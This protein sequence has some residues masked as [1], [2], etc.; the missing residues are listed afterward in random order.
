MIKDIIIHISAG[1]HARLPD[2]RAVTHRKHHDP[3][4]HQDFV[5]LLLGPL[6]PS[7]SSGKAGQWCHEA[8]ENRWLIQPV[9]PVAVPGQDLPNEIIQFPALLIGRRAR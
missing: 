9:W 3:G 1:P 7:L 8:A 4:K 5:P 6:N 2:T